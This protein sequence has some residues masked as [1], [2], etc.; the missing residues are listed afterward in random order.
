MIEK[1][2]A[3]RSTVLSWGN[4]LYPDIVWY[5]IYLLA[6]EIRFI[7]SL[8]RLGCVDIMAK[9]QTPFC[10]ID[11][12]FL[13]N[14]GNPKNFLDPNQ[15]QVNDNPYWIYPLNILKIKKETSNHSL[16]GSNS[17]PTVHFINVEVSLNY[18]NPA[19]FSFK[20]YDKRR[21]FPFQYTLYIKFQSNR[22][23]R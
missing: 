4:S 16:L 5:N 1:I 21:T 22:L 19:A 12:L 20:K 17:I 6:Y 10:Y 15:P 18:S 7:Q 13:I 9:F 11:N 14:V 23:V 2:V 3:T 8:A